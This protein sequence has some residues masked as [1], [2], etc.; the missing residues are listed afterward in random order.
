MFVAS[1]PG[2][3]ALRVWPGGWLAPS[4]GSH[5]AGLQPG[6]YSLLNRNEQRIGQLESTVSAQGAWA[7]L[8]WPLD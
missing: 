8:E 4:S 3:G 6:V 1:R 5:P 7:G 2:E